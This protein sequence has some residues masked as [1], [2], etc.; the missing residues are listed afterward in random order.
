MIEIVASAVYLYWSYKSIELFSDRKAVYTIPVIALVVYTSKAFCHGDSAEELCFPF[1]SYTLFT[2]LKAVRNHSLPSKRELLLTGISASI[3]FWTKFSL[4]GIYIGWFIALSVDLVRR[5]EYRNWLCSILMILTGLAIGTIPWI[6]YFGIHHAIRDWLEVYLYDKLFYYSKI[7]GGNSFLSII[8]ALLRGAKSL[9][10]GFIVGLFLLAVGG[11]YCYLRKWIPE[12]LYTGAML[13]FAFF[14]A[15]AGGRSWPYCALVLAPFICFG[16]IP[17]CLT[18]SLDHN[19]RNISKRLCSWSWYII[20]VVIAYILT[21]NRYLIGVDKDELPQ[22]Q[23][24]EII[25]QTENATL[26]NYGFLDGGFYTTTGIIPNCRSFCE[27]NIPIDELVQ[28][29][30]AYVKDGKCDYIVTRNDE[31]GAVD[32]NNYY[33]LVSTGHFVFEGED[34]SYYLYKLKALD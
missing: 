13:F 4:C 20:L 30:E 7:D 6:L 31:L 14:F 22:Y 26:L 19:E 24:A 28:V 23:F 17:V 25:T 10:H 16:F 8:K 12:L 18:V 29:Q 9:V 33:A 34:Y 11:I 3:V 21:P 32:E 2:A 27:L 1:L 5:K 15:Y